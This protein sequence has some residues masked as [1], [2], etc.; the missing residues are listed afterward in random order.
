[1]KHSALKLKIRLED[2]QDE[3]DWETNQLEN[4]L[5]KKEKVLSDIN[6]VLDYRDNIKRGIEEITSK[7]T[8][9]G[10]NFGLIDLKYKK[11]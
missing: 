4:L 7:I 11:I 3:L 8:N 6:I 2:L 10:C 1:M 9:S 5:L